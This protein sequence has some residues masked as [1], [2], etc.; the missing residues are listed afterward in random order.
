MSIQFSRGEIWEY[1]SLRLRFECELS[2]E[3]LMFYVER[4]LAPFQVTDTHGASSAPDM[5]WALEAFSEGRLRRVS[6]RRGL[7]SARKQA[8]ERDWDPETAK[9]V[10]SQYLKRRF[11]LRELDRLGNFPSSDKAITRALLTIW[12][13]HPEDASKLGSLPPARTVR[14]WLETRGS[15]SER[16]TR[17]L[18]SM[19]GRVERLR[20]VSS[21]VLRLMHREAANYWADRGRSIQDSYA[22]LY[23]TAAYLN[24]RRS[25]R[26]SE[27][28]QLTIPSLETFRREVRRFECF[29]TYAAKFGK[30][31]AEARFKGHGEGLTAPRA[32]RLGCMDHTL[33]DAVAVLCSDTL[34]PM[35]R[36][37][38]TVLI[39]VR[40]RCIVGFVLTYE[41]PSN[42]AAT[43]CIK[44]ANRPKSH[45]LAKF[46]K[47]PVL[48]QIFG[49]FDEIVVD[50]GWELSGTTFEDGM[51]DVGTS[52]RWAPIA[53]PTYK[54][55]VERFFRILNQILNH[56]LPGG[57]LKPELLRELGYDPVKSAVL[58]I[59]QLEDLIWT[60]ISYYHIEEHKGLGCPPA[61]VWAL[62]MKAHGIPVIGDDSQLDKMAG[63]LK[64]NC[65]LT[66][67]GV[68]LF[69]LHFH[70]P[71]L[72]SN[73]LEDMIVSEPIRGKRKGSATI[74]VKV[75]YNPINA[76]EIHVWNS[77]RNVY[78]T[79]PCTHSL[80]TDDLSFWQHHQIRDWTRRKGL[81]FSSERDR[82][83][84]R[85]R[86][87][88]EVSSAMPGLK[89][90]Q[91]RTVARLLSSSRV[92]EAIASGKVT[93]AEAPARHDGLAPI[94]EQDA[95]SL[96]REDGGRPPT[97]PPR[98]GSKR[99]PP[100]AA[101]A[102]PKPRGPRPPPPTSV[103]NT[104]H[105]DLEVTDV[106]ADWKEYAL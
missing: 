74:T 79:L 101:I 90:K 76:A 100:A 87:I 83:E 88:D 99:P 59:T 93:V 62:D 63:A 94:I 37:W 2:D 41:P 18:V 1:D 53:S 10:D 20:R 57:V 19:S 77:R 54:A 105:P 66:T 64:P 42:Y 73:L 45:L 27:L 35:G 49:K 38:L 55:V 68:E 9:T 81:E 12:K 26:H 96:H 4:T 32:L 16:M 56:K 67:S 47:F 11:V 31:K 72:T 51:A 36:P 34:L 82:M 78:V 24:D 95:L 21:V 13:E 29:D 71:V 43:E 23:R 86:L 85:A 92:A 48:S 84:A 25:R 70:D 60:A 69:G 80:Y 30:K 40:T 52:V 102:A 7:P 15:P 46:S 8:A 104:A 39:D 14:R 6:D 22:R 97:R 65:R 3:L 89:I 106:R 17:Q 28:P 58:T 50:N 98:G 91:R 61:S 5:K 33:L 103:E 75:K 44:R